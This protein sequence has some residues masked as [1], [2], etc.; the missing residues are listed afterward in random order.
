VQIT[1]EDLRSLTN[2]YTLQQRSFNNCQ[3]HQ[4]K[5]KSAS[6]AA[7]LFAA[8]AVA[9]PVKRDIVTGTSY[10]EHPRYRQRAMSL[11]FSY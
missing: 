10:V 2:L 9:T 4:T 7:A 3:S 6:V 8:L 5:M 11:N 1:S